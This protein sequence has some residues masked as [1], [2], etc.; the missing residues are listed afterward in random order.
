MD[1]Y[2]APGW[3]EILQHNRLSSFEALWTL[4]ADW[5]EPPNQRRGGWSGVARVSLELPEGGEIHLFLK[6]QENHLRKSWR[7]PFR[8]EPTF[9]AEARNLRLL[10][11]HAVAAPQLVLYQERMGDQ[12]WQV[13]LATREL[14]GQQPLDRL[15]EQWHA[16]G[17]SASRELRRALIPEVAAL[18]RRFHRLRQAHNALHAKHIFIDPPRRRATLIDLEKMRPRLT[19]R[20]AMLRDLDTL[21]RRTARISRSDRLRFL[22]AYL[23]KERVDREVRRIWRRLDDILTRKE[24]RKMLKRKRPR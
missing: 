23:G 12:G 17:W 8:G 4:E 5:F 21:N 3:Q 7:H 22:L 18:L 15:I 20:Q 10:E 6:R 1:D 14:E 2:L 9:R 16:E 11:R 24:R 19:R 13:V